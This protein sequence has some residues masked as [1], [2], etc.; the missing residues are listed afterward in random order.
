MQGG[1]AEGEQGD[2]LAACLSAGR[3]QVEFGDVAQGLAGQA[4]AGQVML[5]FEGAVEA[6]ALVVA[7]QADGQALQQITFAGRRR[8]RHGEGIEQPRR[9][10]QSFLTPPASRRAGPV[11]DEKA[12]G[13]RS[14]P[15]SSEMKSP[16]ACRMLKY[17]GDCVSRCIPTGH[18]CIAPSTGPFPSGGAS[19]PNVSRIAPQNF[20]AFSA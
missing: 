2:P 18:V 9:R 14:T 19:K 15:P 20:R 8:P 10:V 6:L 16:S 12:L 5:V 1:G 17:T 11:A 13:P 3:R 7:E 4:G